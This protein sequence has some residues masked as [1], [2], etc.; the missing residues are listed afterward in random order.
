ML[1]SLG[2]GVT[3]ADAVKVAGSRA[4]ADPVVLEPAAGD[5]VLEVTLEG[6]VRLFLPAE[7]A[8][9]LLAAP[10]GRAS[11]VPGTIPLA[12]SLAVGDGTRG[13]GDWAIEGLRLIGIDLAGRTAASV[14][15]AIDAH[16]VPTPGLY[17]WRGQ[18]LTPVEERL[19]NGNDPW[20]LFLHGTFSNTL[21]SFGPL[22]AQPAQWRRLEAAYRDRILALD[23]HTLTR[24][25]IEN[26]EEALALLPDGAEL[27]LVGYSRG[28]LIGELLARGRLDGRAEAFDAAE[29]GLFDDAGRVEQRASLERLGATLAALRPAIGRY[30]RVGCPAR[31]TTL[32]SDRLDRWLNFVL[33][34]LGMGVGAAASP[35][36]GEVYDLVTAFLL[37][38]IKER[39]DA[40]TIPGLEAMIPGAPLVR[41]LN[42]PGVVATGDLAVLEG[43]IEGAGILGRLKV[44]ATDLFFREDHDL[45]VNTGAMDGGMDRNP[46]ARAFLAQGPEVSHF[47][48]FA[49]PATAA[50]VVDGLLRADDQ[51]GGFEPS[52]LEEVGIV[53][54]PAKRGGAKR[55]VVFVL[56][57]ITGTVLGC[58]DRGRE[59]RIW[60]DLPQLAFGGLRRLAIDQPDIVARE[61]LSLYYGE[62]CD[63]LGASHDVRPWGYD[64]RR[65]ILDN[66][67]DFATVLGSALTATDQPVRIVAHSMGGL[68]ARSAFL[69]A[70]VW[71]RF[72]D[73]AGS[74]LI[75]LG[76]PN[77]GSWSI[78]Y[79][80]MGRDTL[81]G[82]LATLDLT[83]SPREQQAVVVRFP[84]ALQMLPH[85]EAPL[86][87]AARWA[88]LAQLDPS[89]DWGA[90][91]ADDLAIAA[92]FREVF[93]K[94]PADPER[95]LY[96]AGHA[97]TMMGIEEDPTA[98]AGQ[99]IRFRT[100][101]EGDGKVPW[102]S[103]IPLGIS[104][105]YTDAVHGDL[106]R[107]EPAF[108][109]ILDLLETGA[110]RRLPTTPPVA[111]RGAAVPSMK[112]RDTVPMYPDAEDLLL[113]G[114]GGSSKVRA[115][116]KS[117]QDQDRGRARPSCVRQA[118]GDRGALCRRYDQRCGAGARRGAGRPACQAQ[119]AG[120]LSRTARHEHGSARSPDTTARGDRGGPG[121]SRRAGARHAVGNAP[122]RALGL[123]DRGRRRPLRARRWWEAGTARCHHAAGGRRRRRPTDREQHRGPAP[124]GPGGP[125]GARRQRPERARGPG[126]GGGPGQS[127]L[128][129]AQRGAAG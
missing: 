37:A 11:A 22:A 117:T 19:P 129:R 84:G 111:T 10:P 41:L 101:M 120:P 39:A 62:L 71:Q 30:V 42:R 100:S 88:A 49:N 48:Y 21:G 70:K 12:S 57:G 18:A 96:V 74:R 35:F 15:R 92:R 77:G 69:D 31:G 61:P 14:A 64:W 94:A 90:P 114:M 52:P 40:S 116:R 110:T 29:L 95:L 86:F 78:P 128:A 9:E 26:A 106:A 98:P 87:D 56:P 113:A 91:R 36:T 65:S 58:I 20:L 124:R 126:A 68:V 73:R 103:G 83:M 122:S 112:V 54:A 89:G 1:G 81:M 53:A 107:H 76:T 93:A 63:Y 123:R 33:A 108:P 45:V 13:M 3:V 75:Q 27:H 25:P 43:D 79:M 109:A 85:A 46:P 23:H 104:A 119:G 50:R 47:A 7:Q 67:K 51:D 105:W 72:Q 55:P 2:I 6:G 59:R 118:P 8:P 127:R 66:A 28:G 99:R 5:D 121:R 97:P 115:G 32:A 16:Q 60:V 34:A 125:A 17:L 80:L 24:S 82:Y 44:L 102:N 4:A 38:V